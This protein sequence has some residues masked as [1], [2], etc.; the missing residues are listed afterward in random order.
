MKFK[1]ELVFE[2]EGSVNDVQPD[3]VAREISEACQ[4]IRRSEN[5]VQLT[6]VK[7]EQVNDEI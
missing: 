5:E 4:K 3:I 1:I 7:T 6:Y 2:M